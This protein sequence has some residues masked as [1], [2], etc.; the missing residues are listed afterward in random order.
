[1]AKNTK[2]TPRLCRPGK[3]GG[4]GGDPHPYSV[5]KKKNKYADGPDIKQRVRGDP[6]EQRSEGGS[7]TRSAAL[8]CW[9]MFKPYVTLPKPL[10]ERRS[11]ILNLLSVWDFPFLSPPAANANEDAI[12][13]ADFLSWCHCLRGKRTWLGSRVRPMASKT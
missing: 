2:T 7:V 13:G 6:R 4:L 3:S 12:T 8:V 1:M 10:S 11:G 5:K 9:W